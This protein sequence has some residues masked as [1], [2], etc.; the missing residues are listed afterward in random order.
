MGLPRTTTCTLHECSAPQMLYVTQGGPPFTGLTVTAAAVTTEWCLHLLTPTYLQAYFPK[1]LF[2]EW[3]VKA[4]LQAAQ[5]PL[6]REALLKSLEQVGLAAEV[7]AAGPA[8]G[9]TTVQLSYK[10]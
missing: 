4:K 6:G 9:N 10:S 3:D 8:L 5:T 1:W 2:G 7:C